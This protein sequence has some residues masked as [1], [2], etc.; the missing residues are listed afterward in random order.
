MYGCKIAFCSRTSD[1]L[2]ETQEL[3][4]SMNVEN[5]PIQFDALEQESCI[6]AISNTKKSLVI[7]IF[8]LTMLVV[9]Q[10]GV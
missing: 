9:V 8:L 10:D 6:N 2:N 7:L 1:R 5:Y 4:N 3:L